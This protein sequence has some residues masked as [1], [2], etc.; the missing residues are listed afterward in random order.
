VWDALKVLDAADIDKPEASLGM[1]AF[2]LTR[3][4]SFL[5]ASRFTLSD[6]FVYMPADLSYAESKYTHSELF[7]NGYQENHR[8]GIVSHLVN[9]LDLSLF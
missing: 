4:L 7:R 6:A 9:S 5:F 1:Y 3:C 2:H 8:D